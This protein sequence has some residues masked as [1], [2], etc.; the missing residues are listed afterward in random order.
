MVTVEW[1]PYYY[2]QIVNAFV[3]EMTSFKQLHTATSYYIK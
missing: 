3:F 1:A 2:C